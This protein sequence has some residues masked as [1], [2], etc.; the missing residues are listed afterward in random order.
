MI[1]RK[2]LGIL[3]VALV[4]LGLLSYTTKQQR[5]GTVKDGGFESLLPGDLDPASIESIRAWLG[6]EPDSAVELAREGDGWVVPSRWDWSAKQSLVDKLL[7]DLEGLT[8][9]K[10][11]AKEEIFEDFQIDDESGLHVV[12]K[13]SGGTELFHLVVGKAA[14]RGGTFV[15]KGDSKD[16]Y[17][18]PAMLR[19]S[20]GMWG[21]EP[22]SPDAKR[23]IEMRI[24]QAQAT[25]VDKVVIRAGGEETVLEKSFEPMPAPEGE[26][27]EATAAPPAIDRAIYTW[28]NDDRGEF[29]K[30]K[31][32]GIVSTLCSLYAVG[33]ANPDSTREYGLA[34]DA[35][36]VD[37][38]YADGTS[39]SIYFGKTAADT[40]RVYLR[41]GED[42][43]P[44]EIYKTTVDRVFQD[45]SELSPKEG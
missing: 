39:T 45:R 12:A 15:R 20:F 21:E 5:Y 44:A 19:S 8:G 43:K 23:W 9:E 40:M 32:D 24:H 4:A 36:Q 22:K 38:L 37:L 28:K 14:V 18:T 1:N 33:V 30:S 3:A 29:D 26:E 16:I 10:R 17:V 25:E 13:A 7:T 27:S 41:V 2:T 34:E 31:A 6:A 35:R 42:G 11:P